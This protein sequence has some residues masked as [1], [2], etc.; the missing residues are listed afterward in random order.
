MNN[1]WEETR[2]TAQSLVQLTYAENWIL[3]G[4]A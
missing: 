3:C 1:G 2:G 4:V